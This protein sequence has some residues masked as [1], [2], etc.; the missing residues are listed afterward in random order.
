MY[1]VK[2]ILVTFLFIMTAS[3]V[4]VADEVIQSESSTVEESPS[5]SADSSAIKTVDIIPFDEKKERLIFKWLKKVDENINWD[6]VGKR[7]SLVTR[8]IL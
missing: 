6:P 7:W 8:L 1:F 3:K 4:S 2:W 5:D